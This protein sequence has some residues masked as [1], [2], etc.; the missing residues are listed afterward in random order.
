MT[1][2]RLLVAIGLG[3]LHAAHVTAADDSRIEYRQDHVQRG[4]VPVAVPRPEPIDLRTLWFH[5]QSGQLSAARSEL[6]RLRE[7]HPQWQPDADI[8]AALDPDTAP[9]RDPYGER[10]QAIADLGSEALEALPLSKLTAAADAAR[11]RDDGGNLRMLAWRHLERREPGIALALFDDACAAGD[12]KDSEG[13]AIALAR[14]ARAAAKA[15]DV[16]RVAALSRRSR[17]EGGGGLLL[18]SAWAE[19]AAGRPDSAEALFRAALPRAAAVEGL[20]LTLRDQGRFD[21]ALDIACAS[22][23]QSARTHELCSGWLEEAMADAYAGER[24][25][26]VLTLYGRRTQVPSPVPDSV[27]E[28]AAWSHY[29]L[30][31]RDAAVAAFHKRLEQRPDTPG[32]AAALVNLLRDDPS[33]LAA[34]AS[35]HP[36][37]AAVVRREA[38]DTALARKQFDRAAR[39]DATPALQNRGAL[40][41]TLALSRR[42]RSGDRGLARLDHDRVALS[43]SGL[44][45]SWRL[46]GTLGWSDFHSGVPAPGADFG[47][48]SQPGGV[49][50]LDG[51]SD[52]SLHLWARHEGDSYSVYARVGR[53]LWRQPAGE[54]LSALLQARFFTDPLSSQIELFQRPIADSLLSR[55]G[56]VDPAD[57]SRWGGVMD[58]GVTGQATWSTASDWHLSVEGSVSQQNGD[59]VEDNHAVGARIDLRSGW[60]GQRWDGPLDYWQIGPFASW[61]GFDNNQFVF[62]RGNGGYFSPQDE[63]RI[64]LSSELL[65]REGRRWQL[66]AGIEIAWT[67]ITEDATLAAPRQRTRGVNVDVRLQGH[68]LITPRFQLGARLQ[69]TDAR[70]FRGS[71]AG[72]TLQWFPQARRAVWSR[73]LSLDHGD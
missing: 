26:D 58:R 67:D 22:G 19:R 49:A 46:G 16:D 14:L 43:L 18:D 35:K 73:E 9:V 44:Y 59:D 3:I 36:G 39:L 62:T 20:A 33:G 37:V 42:Q 66:R 27:D 15:G 48:P 7:A 52:P 60:P 71:Y 54:A 70:G 28:L 12:P 50:P 41:A 10:M 24:Y 51:V 5:L 38:A 40:S 63:Y 55:T 45:D 4:D 23:A 31:Q 29:A 2:A 61:R 6:E 11:A 57:G 53:D 64:G 56:A 47:S 17:Q 72:L 32:M 30:G 68:W 25:R 69:G 8:R 1:P 21:A 13:L 34:A 65:T